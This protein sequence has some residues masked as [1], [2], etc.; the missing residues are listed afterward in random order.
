VTQIYR[1]SGDTITKAGENV[2]AN[3]ER[4]YGVAAVEN[5]FLIRSG[6]RA[7]LVRRS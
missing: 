1:A 4:T 2:L 6:N 7:L 5:G 3:M